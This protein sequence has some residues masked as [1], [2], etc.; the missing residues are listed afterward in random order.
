MQKS[1]AKA[2]YRTTAEFESG[3][4]TIFVWHPGYHEGMMA[5][6]WTVNFAGWETYGRDDRGESTLLGRATGLDQ[7][8][9]AIVAWDAERGR[10]R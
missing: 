1:L 9:A 10:S 2:G 7:A 5:I 8:L 3:E 6:G 4:E